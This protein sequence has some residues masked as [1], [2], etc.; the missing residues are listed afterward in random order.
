IVKLEDDKG[1][2]KFD[3]V[4]KI[5]IQNSYEEQ[6]SPDAKESTRLSFRGD[7]AAIELEAGRKKRLPTGVEKGGMNPGGGRHGGGM[8]GGG[9]G[10]N[11]MDGG[12]GMPDS[13]FSTAT[14]QNNIS[15]NP[16]ELK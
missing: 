12:R 3:L 11:G 5:K 14:P 13:G 10:G 15:Q 6:A 2:Y 4:K 16:I 8:R 7:Q 1:D 9:M